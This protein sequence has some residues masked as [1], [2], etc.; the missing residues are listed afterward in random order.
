MSFCRLACLSLPLLVCLALATTGCGAPPLLVGASYAADGGLLAASNKTSTDHLLSMVSKK[1]CAMWRAVRSQPI[2]TER[3]NGEDPYA[4]DYAQPQRMVA[5][6]GVHYAAPLRPAAN[7][8]AVSWD[9]AVY[10]T[11]PAPA[12][13]TPVA[14]L[15]PAVADPAPLQPP[16]A[17]PAAAAKKA[18]P[19][20]RKA[21]RGRAVSGS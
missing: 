5:E 6:D 13:A 3:E 2:C 7:A 14:A 20:T 19:P 11:A 12:T 17:K 15:P 9:P 4:V 16:A 21:S 10:A 18:K 8:P 1:D